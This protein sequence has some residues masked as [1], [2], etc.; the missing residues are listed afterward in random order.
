LITLTTTAQCGPFAKPEQRILK[1]TSNTVIFSSSSSILDLSRWMDLHR[2]AT[3]LTHL[4]LPGAHDAATWN[5]TG[6]LDP[7]AISTQRK[8]ISW[9]LQSG[10]RFFD[11]RYALDPTE[12]NLVFWHHNALLLQGAT[13]ADVFSSFYAW[14]DDHATETVLISLQY[15]GGTLPGA[16]DSEKVQWMLYSILTDPAAKRYILQTRDELGTLG[17]AR[18]K[19]ILVRRFS[20]DKLPRK[21]ETALPGIHLPSSLWPDNARSFQMVYNDKK[22]LIADIEDY[23]EPDVPPGSN[24]SLA[25]AEKVDAVKEHLDEAIEAGHWRGDE[26]FITFTSA[27][28]TE[29]EPLVWPEAMALGDGK[30]TPYGGVNAQLVR[31]LGPRRGKRLGIV[32]LDFWDEPDNLVRDIIGL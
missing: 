25:I 31:Y 30:R 12:E 11:L 24:T 27:R 5:Y 14:L 6:P 18:G 3:L 9:G 26:L 1:S 23:Y 29:S 21:A 2:D 10:V 16:S 13:V 8:S 7:G 20:L 17:E 32:V 19:V 15:E 4:S 28:R 22:G